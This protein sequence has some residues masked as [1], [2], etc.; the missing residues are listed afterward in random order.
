MLLLGWAIGLAFVACTP[1]EQSI[2][3]RFRL[4]NPG[5]VHRLQFYVHDAVLV[6]SDGAE[7]PV[8]FD[9]ESP[10]QSERVAL[11]DLSAGGST[12]TREVIQGLAP[13]ASYAG[14]RF[15]IGV[16]F[17]LNH[18]NPMTASSPL[19]RGEMFWSWQSGYKF[20]RLDLSATEHLAAFH[21]GS[22][23]CS[24]AS[25]VR[26]PA[27]PCAQPNVIHAELKDFDPH[28]QTVD[29]N[30]AEIIAA[31][32]G[33]EVRTCTGDYSQGACASALATTGLDLSS[34]HCAGEGQVK[35]CSQRLFTPSPLP[36]RSAQ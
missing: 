18:S 4:E 32:N 29:V 30:V 17:D 34:G 8:R 15:A 7:Y 5:S 1:R 27:Q 9:I 33:T 16:P 26:P 13:S 23:G 21:L 12:P 11:I 24:S 35:R 22:T 19:N 36:T 6:G 20:L 31:L 25:A 28:R 3:L 14:V 2:Q 10:W